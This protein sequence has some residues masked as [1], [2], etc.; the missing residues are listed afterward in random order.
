MKQSIF[1]QVL[2][3][4]TQFVAFIMPTQ[5]RQISS[6]PAR[7]RQLFIIYLYLYINQFTIYRISSLHYV[8]RRNYTI[9]I[10]NQFVSIVLQFAPLTGAPMFTILVAIFTTT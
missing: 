6:T 7:Q 2:I 10:Y 8:P 1:F 4:F 3:F 5:F 9:Q